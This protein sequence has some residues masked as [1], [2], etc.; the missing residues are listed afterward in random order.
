MSKSLNLAYPIGFSDMRAE[1]F[2]VQEMDSDV[3]T[4]LGKGQSFKKKRNN[5]K[6]QSAGKMEKSLT[7][8]LKRHVPPPEGE[9]ARLTIDVFK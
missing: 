9:I 5:G 1:V 8:R 3:I 2:D 6:K 7:E 4:A